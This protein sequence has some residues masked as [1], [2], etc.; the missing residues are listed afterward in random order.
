MNKINKINKNTIMYPKDIWN[1][2][3]SYLLPKN[4]FEF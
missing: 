3:L 2:I 1:I 4:R